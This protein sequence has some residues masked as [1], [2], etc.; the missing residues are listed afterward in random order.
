MAST[1]PAWLLLCAVAAERAIELPI[2]NRNT[3]ALKARGAVE[4]G[5]SHYPAIVIVHVAWLLAL[6]AWIWW[7]KPSLS[8]LWTSLFLTVEILRVWV[9]ISLGRYWT[10]RI[11]TLPGAPL[12]RRGPYRFMRHPN[13]AVVVAEIAILPLA[14]HAPVIAAV[15]S[16]ANA[17]VLV[18]RVRVEKEALKARS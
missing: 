3:A 14:L 6:A 11:I 10:T 9:M 18:I 17:I 2:A 7:T 8:V 4:L 16:L 5:A 13:Y 12:V 15:F 1:L